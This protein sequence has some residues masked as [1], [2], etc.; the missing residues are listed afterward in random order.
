MISAAKVMRLSQTRQKVASN[1]KLKIGK[2]RASLKRSCQANERTQTGKRKAKFKP[3]RIA[4]CE[5]KLRRILRRKTAKLENRKPKA[6]ESKMQPIKIKAF[7]ARCFNLFRVANN[8]NSC[9]FDWRFAAS[10]NRQSESKQ[11][12]AAKLICALPLAVRR[13]L[14]LWLRRE[15]RVAQQPRAAIAAS[16]LAGAALV[17][18]IGARARLD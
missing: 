9:E 10:L 2:F 4:A 3:E 13:C 1:S 6:S 17:T 15:L 14:P 18:S 5:F 16:L 8:K 12:L 11:I 7:F